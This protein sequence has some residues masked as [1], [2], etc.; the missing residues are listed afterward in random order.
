VTQ[1]ASRDRQISQLRKPYCADRSSVDAENLEAGVFAA[2]P[3]I[4]TCFVGIAV[5][6]FATV[7][8]G[9]REATAGL[10]GEWP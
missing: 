8:Q 2:H 3:A 7:A 5:P 6:I 9:N 10:A 4:V 1:Y